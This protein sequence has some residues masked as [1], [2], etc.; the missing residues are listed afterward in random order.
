MYR[1][2]GPKLVSTSG[3]VSL[4]A[5]KQDTLGVRPVTISTILGVQV[6]PRSHR[7][8]AAVDIEYRVLWLVGWKYY[9]LVAG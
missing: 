8:G 3:R 7:L 1:R 9:N 4:L 6:S 2:R 5:F